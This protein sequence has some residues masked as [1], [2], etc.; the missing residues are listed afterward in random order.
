VPYRLESDPFRVRSWRGI[1]VRRLRRE[2]SGRIGF[3]I[4]P[5]TV[6]SA[7]EVRRRVG[8][9][10]YPDSYDSPARFIRREW[11][12]LADG[13]KGE[14]FCFTCTFR[15]WIDAGRATHAVVTVVMADGRRRAV[16]AVRRGQRWVTR[17]P[18][19]GLRAYVEAGDVRDRYG[20]RN[21]TRSKAVAL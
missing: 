7:G 10:D 13:G 18:V 12:F 2:Q 11:Q 20:N 19:R 5:R 15:P 21:G 6:R 16:P 17:R 1:T 8:P 9:I 14:W 4:G 3:R